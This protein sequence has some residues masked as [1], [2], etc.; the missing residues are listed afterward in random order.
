MGSPQLLFLFPQH[1][2]YP[3]NSWLLSVPVTKNKVVPK[4]A[5]LANPAPVAPVSPAIDMPEA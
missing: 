5:P 3:M 1:Q 2:L 4:A